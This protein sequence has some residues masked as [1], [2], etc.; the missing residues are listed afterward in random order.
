M[1]L[2]AYIFVLELCLGLATTTLRK[3]LLNQISPERVKTPQGPTQTLNQTPIEQNP[4]LPGRAILPYKP[5][6]RP[7]IGLIVG[8][9]G[10]N[11]PSWYRSM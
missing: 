4:S 3:R 6:K 9:I 1:G 11:S 5:L 7:F 8:I 2:Q 10:P